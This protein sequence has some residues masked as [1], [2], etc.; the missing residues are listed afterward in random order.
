MPASGK[1]LKKT[2]PYW[3][4]RRRAHRYLFSAPTEI[5]DFPPSRV[6]IAPTGDLSRFGCYIETTKPFPRGTQIRIKIAH[7]GELFVGNGRVAFHTNDGMGVAFSEVD[8]QEQAILDG[9][10]AETREET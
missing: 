10:L 5:T 2:E 1:L 9:W 8:S 6:L 3:I 7:A 4:E